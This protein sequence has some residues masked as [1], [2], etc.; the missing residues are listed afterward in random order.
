MAFKP[1]EGGRPKGA[2][3]KVSRKMDE[4]FDKAFD[5]LQTKDSTKLEQWAEDNP[6]EF[7]KLCA[8]R[9]T[10]NTDSVSRVITE[11]V[12]DEQARVMAEE[13]IE[14]ARAGNQAVGEGESGRLH[15]G[16]AAGLPTGGPTQE[17]SAGA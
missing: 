14:S 11:S 10:L 3:N 7:Y 9:L 4:A 15:Q 13:F 6:T 12:S 8:K 17:D 2:K 5:Y 16:D 1:G